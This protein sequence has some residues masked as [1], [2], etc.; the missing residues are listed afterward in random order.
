MRLTVCGLQESLA[1]VGGT[2]AE[3]TRN[4]AMTNSNHTC[5]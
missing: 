2:L 1:D 4:H 3:A 5:M